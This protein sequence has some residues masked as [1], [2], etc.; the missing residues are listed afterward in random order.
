MKVNVSQPKSVTAGDLRSGGRS[1]Y[2]RQIDNEPE[3]LER[4]YRLRYQVYCVER[5]FLRAED[6]ANDIEIDRFDRHSIHV[7]AVDMHGELAGTARVVQPSELGL[8]MFGHCTIFPHETR[9][10][11]ANPRLVEV[12]RLAASRSY[13]RRRTDE[14]Q[15]ESGADRGDANYGRTERRRQHEVVFLTVLEAAYQASKRAGATHWMAA[16]EKSLHRMLAQRGFPFHQ[17]GPESDYFGLVAP[18]SMDLKEFEAGILSGQFPHLDDFLVG[19]E[20]EAC[21]RASDASRAAEA[22]VSA[23]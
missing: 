3:L 7:G 23:R 19:L 16:M 5:K 12:S 18:Y 21:G 4:S 11:A 15:T 1:F 6:Y 14:L 9:F 17:I 22:L 10:D 8:P 20:G 2:A 13:R